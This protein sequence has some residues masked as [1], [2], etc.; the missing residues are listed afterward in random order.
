MDSRKSTEAFALCRSPTILADLIPNQNDP[1]WQCWLAEVA[2][3]RFLTRKSFRRSECKTQA[4]AVHQN[5]LRAFEAVPQWQDDENSYPK[6]K[7]HMGDHYGEALDEYGSFRGIWCF[8]GEGF[9]QA[10]ACPHAHSCHLPH[11]HHAAGY[12]ADV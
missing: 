12:Q 5:L 10:R 8:S 3:I 9:L 2:E 7:M 4:M 11:P 1:V 6:P